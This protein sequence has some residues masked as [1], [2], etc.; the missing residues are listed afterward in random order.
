VNH[1]FEVEADGIGEVFVFGSL[2]LPYTP[3]KDASQRF[4]ASRFGASLSL[5]HDMSGEINK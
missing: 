4:G 2:L 1:W 3:I 5:A